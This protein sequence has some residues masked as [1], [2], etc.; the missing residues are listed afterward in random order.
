M[1]RIVV[2]AMQSLMGINSE[3]MERTM[4]PLPS[5]KTADTKEPARAMIRKR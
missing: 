3:P 2:R 4:K 5:P 1:N